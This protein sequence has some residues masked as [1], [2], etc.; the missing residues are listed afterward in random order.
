MNNAQPNDQLSI[1]IDDDSSRISAI[2]FKDG[3]K[4]DDKLELRG[5]I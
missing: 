2:I 3:P 1:I 5:F 4:Y